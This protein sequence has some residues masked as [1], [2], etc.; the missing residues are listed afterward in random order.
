MYDIRE[1]RK[2]YV[3]RHRPDVLNSSKT[4]SRKGPPTEILDR[5]LCTATNE[6]RMMNYV[7]RTCLT[8]MTKIFYVDYLHNHEFPM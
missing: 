2:N 3:N 8:S 7:Y 1:I 4:K 5:H 6:K